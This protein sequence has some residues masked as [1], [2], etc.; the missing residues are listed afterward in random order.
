MQ[1]SPFSAS[2]EKKLTLNGF[3]IKFILVKEMSKVQVT[4]G[5]FL[6]G[7]DHTFDPRIHTPQVRETEIEQRS[8]NDPQS[9]HQDAE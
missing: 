7:M 8:M 9:Q 3:G 1:T 2:R 6:Y 5:T 4:Y